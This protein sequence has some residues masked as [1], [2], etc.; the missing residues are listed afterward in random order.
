MRI[1]I[2]KCSVSQLWYRNEIGE[3]YDVSREVTGADSRFR[4]IPKYAVMDK[5]GKEFG[6]VRKEDAEIVS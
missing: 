4:S 2:K 3:E 1:K 5:E 6:F